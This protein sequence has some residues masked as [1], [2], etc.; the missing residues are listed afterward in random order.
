MGRL[1]RKLKLLVPALTFRQIWLQAYINSGS[2]SNFNNWNVEY[3]NTIELEIEAE[4]FTVVILPFVND[5]KT[6]KIYHFT[7]VLPPIHNGRTRSTLQ[8]QLF[9]K[10][11]CNLYVFA[12]Y[13]NYRLL[14]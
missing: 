1:H 5:L 4:I 12:V 9:L 3:S 13:G 2:G 14:R 10:K 8:R 6:V 11:N 7:A